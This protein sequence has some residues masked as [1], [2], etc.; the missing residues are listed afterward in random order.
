MRGFWERLVSWYRTSDSAASH[1]VRAAYEAL[2]GEMPI[3]AGGTALFAIFSLIPTLAAAVAI[4]GIAKDPNEIKEH[5]NGLET[6][7]PKQV[8]T[9]LRDQL[10]RQAQQSKREIGL[11]LGVTV[12]LSTWSA[13][14]AARA[15]I[16]SLNRA[17]RVRE[18]RRTW[19]KL[20]VTIAMGAVTIFGVLV[21]LGVVVAFPAI[22]AA[23]SLPG[24]ELVEM[25]RWP[26]LIAVVFSALMLLYRYAPSPRPMGDNRHL[27]EGALTATVMLLLVSIGLSL[28]VSNFAKYDV[29]YGAFGSAVVLLLWFYLAVISLVVGGFVN[30]ELERKSGAPSPDRSMY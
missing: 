30:A 17:Y 14:S 6:V 11:A 24:Y 4:Y 19:Q 9:F 7:V 12:A 15:L 20:L 22:W 2:L 25:V 10:E 3:L 27:W 5:L 23:F 8:V 26:V 29:W 1:W 21:V 28:W 16:D 18:M 13:R